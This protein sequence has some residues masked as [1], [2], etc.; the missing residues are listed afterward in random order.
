MA[1]T[2]FEPLISAAWG[3]PNSWKLDEYKKRGGYK[4]LEKALEMAPAQIID[5]VKKSNLRGR[6]GAGFPTGLKWS[7]VPKDSPKPKYLAVNGDESEPGTFKDRYILE[8]DPHMMLE[9]IAIASYALGVHTCYVYL[10]GEFK[11]QAERTNAAIREAY[12]AGIFGKKVLGKDYQ[13]DCY[14]VRGAGAYI[15]GEETALLE[16]L[17]G[18]KGWPRLKPPFP[19]VVGLF[20]SPTVVNNVETLASV[21]HIFTRGPAWYAGLGTDKSGGTRLV[22]LSGTVNRPGVYEVPLEATF[23]QLIF[24]DKYG[25]GLPAGRKVKAVIPGGSSAPILSPDE[26]DV[27]MEFEAVKVKQTMAGSGGVIVMDD[28]TCMVRSLWRVA[29]FY[30]E[31]SCGQCTPCREGTPWQ[32]RLLRKLEEGRGEPGDVEIL[33]NVASSIAPYPPI[34]LG[35]TICA[36]GDAAAL[37]T[38]SF[39]MRFRD[40]FEAHIREHRCPFGDKPWGAFGDWS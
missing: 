28:T 32:T 23:N 1:T 13:L 38:H 21:P 11:F 7:F 4:G 17:E 35:N 18:K 40:E 36:L 29:R 16:S 31:E 20:G 14:V 30:A 6:G 19:A 26:L 24:D 12:A 33:S 9:G 34:G 22:C 15:C 27:A 2:A 10:R 39:L 37:P 25:R 5:E 8:H 3:K